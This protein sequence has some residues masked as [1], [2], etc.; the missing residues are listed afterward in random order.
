MYAEFASCAKRLG[1]AKPKSVIDLKERTPARSVS[2]SQVKPAHWWASRAGRDMGNLSRRSVLRSSLAAA[3]AGTLA[4]HYI[5]NA[6]STTAEV[7]WPQGFVQEE[8]VAIKKVVADYE[9]ASGN[10]IDLSIMP[11]APQRQK[12][13]A[14]V[15]SGVVPDLFRDN[16]N[17]IVALY[18]WEDKLL[19]ASDVVET[20][21]EEYT[22]TALLNTY[23]YNNVTKKRSFYGVPDLTAA[24]PNHIWR[25]LVEKAGYKIDDIPKTWD[26]FYD[27]FKEVQKS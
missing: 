25:P 21:K 12:I 22:E 26:A 8:D 14:A 9:K 13:V 27:F 7:W 18:A 10:K 6:A 20:Q 4:R 3:A 11:F 1:A 16:P 15:Q 24:L 5:A 17:E 2:V 19:D 23:C